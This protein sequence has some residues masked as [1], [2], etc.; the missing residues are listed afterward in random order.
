MDSSM[1]IEK[2]TMIP[3]WVKDNL[4]IIRDIF[5]HNSRNNPQSKVE[6]Q[7]RH[8]NGR[9][10]KHVG[11]V[12]TTYFNNRKDVQ[13]LYFGD[14]IL[15]NITKDFKMSYHRTMEKIHR[16]WNSPRIEEEIQFWEFI[17]IEFD[18]KGLK[19]IFVPH[20]TLDENILDDFTYLG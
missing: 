11:W 20:Y 2:C 19:F 3:E 5:P 6:I 8:N 10:T 17:D 15:S 7:Y 12:V 16:D 14:D 18:P 13:R 4:F 9:I 1:F